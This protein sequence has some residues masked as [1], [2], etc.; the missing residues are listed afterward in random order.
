MHINNRKVKTK[1]LIAARVV[2]LEEDTLRPNT[3]SVR[4]SV[5]P[6]CLEMEPVLV[7]FAAT[8]SARSND[9]DG[10]GNG[11][12]YLLSPGESVI[13]T[14]MANSVA[15]DFGEGNCNT[16]SSD[17]TSGEWQIF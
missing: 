13:L 3:Q 17:R 14:A 1:G 11:T 7:T 6:A 9:C 16:A 12:S 15:S 5:N 10:Q 8:S 4:V 2:M